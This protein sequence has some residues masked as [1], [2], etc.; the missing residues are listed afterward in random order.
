MSDTFEIFVDDDRY[1]V[2]TLHLIVAV[3]A[4]RAEEL[5]RRLLDDSPHHLGV[6]ICLDGRRLTGLG[7][8]ATCRVSSDGVSGEQSAPD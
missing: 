4:L 2:P 3:N 6:E 1:A 7:T 8:F 5:A